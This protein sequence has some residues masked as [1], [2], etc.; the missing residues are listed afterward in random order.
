[1][2]STIRQ[3]KTAAYG[4]GIAVFLVVVWKILGEQTYLAHIQHISYF[5]LAIAF[6]IAFTLF[7]INGAIIAILTSQNYQTHIKIGDMVLLPFMMH[8]WSFIIPFRGGLLFSAFFLKMKYGVKGSDSIAI[9]MYTIYINLMLTGLCGI[10]FVFKNHLLASMWTI[11]SILLLFSPAVIWIIKY[12]LDRLS[13]QKPA[14]LKNLKYMLAAANDSSLSLLLNYKIGAVVFI[15]TLL[16]FILYILFL[17]WITAS[18]NFVT[19]F[20][21]IVIFA[22]MMRL[23]TFV[24]IV[25]GNMGIQE[26][27]SG[28]AYYLVGGSLNDGLAIAVAIRF[29]SLVLTFSLGAL[30]TLMSMRHFKMSAVNQLWQALTRRPQV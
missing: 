27:F 15:L 24:R 14:I 9:G 10:Y 20:D 11:L 7:L 29:L 30:G 21:R 16:N 8:L 4:V 23:S 25:P 26:I 28:G 18:L 19:T 12:L 22:L 1:M 5:N 3:K 17:L 13:F 2:K 6:L